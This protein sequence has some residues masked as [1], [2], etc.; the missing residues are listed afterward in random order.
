MCSDTQYQTNVPIY[1]QIMLQIK[2]RIITGEWPPGEKVPPV[3]ELAEQF[4]VN[5]NTMQRSLSELEREGFLYTERTAGRFTT[6]DTALIRREREELAGRVTSHYLTQMQKLGYTG[7]EIAAAIASC[8][9][10][11]GGK[12]P[13]GG[14]GT[15]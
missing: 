9:P 8:M 6:T 7:E 3:R 4:G 10:Q 11:E 13:K 15:L 2:Q 12:G 14:R 1:L 5:P